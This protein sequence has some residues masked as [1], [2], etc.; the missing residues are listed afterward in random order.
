MHGLLGIQEIAVEIKT[1]NLPL[2]GLVLERC[3]GRQGLICIEQIEAV[4]AAL[5]LFGV[6]LRN[7]VWGLGS[8]DSIGGGFTLGACVPWL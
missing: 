4:M 2:V 5:L 3:R 1:E 6:R 7:V 8:M